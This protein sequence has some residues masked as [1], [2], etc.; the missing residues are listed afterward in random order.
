MLAADYRR[1]IPGSGQ[2]IGY[3][4]SGSVAAT[5]QVGVQTYA[6]LVQALGSDPTVP[7][8]AIVSADT[9]GVASSTNGQLVKESDPP[10][11][12]ACTPGDTVAA[13]GIDANGGTLYI[14]EL[15]K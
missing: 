12:I 4:V 1:Q 6:V 2:Q 14:T 10:V 3:S 8:G 7:S 9:S 15:S 13:F 11:V 5:K